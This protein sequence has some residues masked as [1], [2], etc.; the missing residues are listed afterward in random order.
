M[1]AKVLT[2]AQQKGGAGKT[3]LVAQLAATWTAAGKRVAVVD[4]DPQGSLAQWFAAREQYATQ[5]DT[6]HL[7]AVGGWRLTN[8]LA[9]LKNLHDIIIIDSPPHAETESKLA[10]RAADLVLV[11][12]Q[13]SPMDVWATGGTVKLAQGERRPV[14]VV[15]NRV[16]PRANIVEAIRDLLDRQGLPVAET[17]L[18]NRVAFAASMM[19]GKGVVESH[20][21]SP[22]ADEIRALAAEL[23]KRLSV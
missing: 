17:T 10:V 19:E 15:M 13:P 20:H 22:A 6:L 4:I 12:V 18:G 3:S 5:D 8:E 16:P 11:P 7:S 9:R 1:T 21:L 23:E 14:L 2:V